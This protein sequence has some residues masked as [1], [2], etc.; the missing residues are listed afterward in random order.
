M[1]S[2]KLEELSSFQW[3][4]SRA[5]SKS[6]NSELL[7]EI[8]NLKDKLEQS[9]MNLADYISTSAQEKKLLVILFGLHFNDFSLR[10]KV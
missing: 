5:R 9:E 8:S 3:G 6:D 2:Q 7:T 4:D 1:S 10:K